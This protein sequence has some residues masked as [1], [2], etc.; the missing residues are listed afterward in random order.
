MLKQ[1][2]IIDPVLQRYNS[3]LVKDTS[4]GMDIE[5]EIEQVSKE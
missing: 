1:S 4:Q 5:N 3:V 2:D